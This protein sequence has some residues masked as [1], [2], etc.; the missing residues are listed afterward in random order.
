MAVGLRIGLA[1][2][3][4]GDVELPISER[5]FAGGASSLRG[6]E[7]DFAGPI[8]TSTWKPLG[9][10]AL[11]VA[12]AEIRVPLLRSIHFAGFYD[13]GNVFGTISDIAFSGFSHTLGVGLRIK[14]PFGPFRVDYGYHLNIPPELRSSA[15]N[16]YQGLTPGHLFITV[17]PPF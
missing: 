13:A 7:T 8:D 3:Y 10:N 15:L 5:F 16:N 4:G 9:G 11:V 1:H 17:G 12:S 2:P 14:T 6:F